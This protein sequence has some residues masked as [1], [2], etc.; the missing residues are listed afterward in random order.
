MRDV[1]TSVEGPAP[2]PESSVGP[3]LYSAS[4]IQL[5]EDLKEQFGQRL[6][7]SALKLARDQGRALIA[8]EDIWMIVD[9]LG[10]SILDEASPAGR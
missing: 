10:G 9:Q 6:K 7:E 2:S 3:M 1:L 8:P 5:V 4:A